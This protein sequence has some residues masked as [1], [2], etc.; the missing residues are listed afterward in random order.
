[1]PIFGCSFHGYSFV[2]NSHGKL[3]S[4]NLEY[5]DPVSLPNKAIRQVIVCCDKV[6]CKLYFLT[7]SGDVYSWPVNKQ[8][9]SEKRLKTESNRLND[10][11]KQIGIEINYI[12]S[13]VCDG[14]YLFSKQQC[15]MYQNG[16]SHTTDLGG[17]SS[18][19]TCHHF[20]QHLDPTFVDFFSMKDEGFV[21]GTVSGKVFYRDSG[22]E[23]HV[24]DV[25][26]IALED[27][28]EVKYLELIQLERLC[29]LLVIGHLGTVMIYHKRF[30]ESSVGFQQFNIQS[31]VTY[32]DKIK[33][34]H[35]VVSTGSGKVSLLHFGVHQEDVTVESTPFQN[36]TQISKLRVVDPSTLEVLTHAHE[37]QRIKYDIQA[38]SKE[39]DP[40]AIRALIKDAL[41][42]LAFSEND[43][44]KI[45]EDEQ[46]LNQKL[47]SVNRTLYALQSIH[48]KRKRNICN[49]LEDTGFEFA[50]CPVVKTASLA[51]TCLQPMSYLRVHIKTF[52]FLQL[53]QWYLMLDMFSQ[54]D[55]A[56][57]TRMLPIVGFESHYEQ[58]IERYTVWERDIPMNS[59]QLPLKVTCNLVMMSEEPLRFPV[60]E[61]IID[62]LHFAIPCSD[63]TIQGIQRKGLDDISNELHESYRLQMLLDKTGKYP[64]ARFLQ[65]HSSKQITKKLFYNK[66]IHIRCS[67][68]PSLTDEQYRSIL[69][70][71]LNEGRTVDE[72]KRIMLNAEHAYFTLASFPASPIVL[73]LSKTSMNE[74]DITIQCA[75]PP[76][77]FKT[78]ASLVSRLFHYYIKDESQSTLLNEK[79]ISLED[80]IIELQETYQ[81]DKMEIDNDDKELLG[82]I[83]QM[84]E[85]LYTIYSELPVGFVK[86]V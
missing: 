28:E 60:T 19:V 65:K 20:F 12:A 77:L 15:K 35:Y 29:Y 27:D 1:M 56:G 16:Y 84:I 64:F 80:S 4:P 74:L 55:K 63:D 73:K 81:Q 72:I 53:E 23:S 2:M 59:I 47:T 71:L 8:N 21:Y 42:E 70:S 85:K 44:K 40:Q 43:L 32:V 26:L 22:K 14:I 69:P 24:Q 45:E 37:Y 38:I 58:G 6:D 5:E 46:N 39:N 31:P 11:L 10:N 50:V 49:S 75:H 67:I 7:I 82:S 41:E 61:M 17:L 62:D 54:S 76:A 30:G 86:F 52:K 25:K 79:L 48:S 68:D 36:L 66:S 13:A 78:E 51:N 18:K 3:F 9:R 33:E 57:E 34:M 83:N